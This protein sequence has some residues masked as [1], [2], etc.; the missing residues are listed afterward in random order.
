MFP[1]LGTGSSLGGSRDFPFAGKKDEVFGRAQGS[2][3]RTRPAGG[4]RSFLTQ[5]G[6]AFPWGLLSSNT[7]SFLFQPGICKPVRC[8]EKAGESQQ[9]SP[10][11]QG[12]GVRAWECPRGSRRDRGVCPTREDPQRCLRQAGTVCVS[13]AHG[14]SPPLSR[15]WTWLGSAPLQQHI[16]GSGAR[17]HGRGGIMGLGWAPEPPAPAAAEGLHLPH[18]AAEGGTV[19]LSCSPR[20]GTGSCGHSSEQGSAVSC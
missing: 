4:N 5:R 2:R 14:G 16:L 3:G 11:S 9:G 20:E 7:G 17:P 15:T 12:N 18:L 6:P 1:V 8:A 19:L 10:T 13:P